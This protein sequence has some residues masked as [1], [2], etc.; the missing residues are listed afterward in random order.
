[1]TLVANGSGVADLAGNALANDATDKWINGA[2][3]ANLDN[4][5]NQLDLIRMLQ[6]GTYLSGQPTTWLGGDFDGNGR[7]D[8]FD[9][10]IMQTTM[11]QHYLQGPFAAVAPADLSAAVDAVM[12]GLAEE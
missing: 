1:M 8:Q 3:D 10:I 9:I 5:F 12:A 4:E 6:G 11:P 7:F 2:G